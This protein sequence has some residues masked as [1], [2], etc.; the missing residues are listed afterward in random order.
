MPRPSGAAAT[1]RGTCF[2]LHVHAS[3]D[4]PFHYL[5][6]GD[7]VPL[8]VAAPST[9]LAAPTARRIREWSPQAGHNFHAQLY[10]DDG[11]YHLWF[12]GGTW[13]TIDPEVPRIIVPRASDPVA[14]EEMLW[15][16]PAG[17]CLLHRGY[18]PIHAASVEVGNKAILLAAPG[19]F[20]KTT[21]AAAFHGAGFRV[22]S[23][24]ITCISMH[25]ELSVIPGPAMLRVRPDVVDRL[26]LSSVEEVRRSE[27]RISLA[28]GPA[29]RGN[30][31][32]V[33]IQAAFFLR[34][35]S[36]W[37]TERV[38][39]AHAVPDLWTLSQ[40]LLTDAGIAACFRNTVAL[41][42]G[43]PILNFHRPL[44]LGA[45][46]RTVNVIVD[47]VFGDRTAPGRSQ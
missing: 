32:P 10:Q 11:V 27:S 28:L 6:H 42:N 5:R 34:F 12:E 38:R 37:R 25:P 45:L 22:L 1:G 17:L 35:S 46:Q 20:G 29:G 26:P 7:G 23:E 4:L 13:F 47:T 43:I 39:P 36:E 18:L 41:A 21:L 9:P 15:M 44:E 16:I 2:G 8:Y 19:G 3:S 33:P 14:R 40:R 24:D 31:D 30:C